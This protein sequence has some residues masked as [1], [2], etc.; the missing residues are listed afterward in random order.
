MFYH[1]K[2]I[3]Y[4]VSL[5][6]AQRVPAVLATWPTGSAYLQDQLKRAMSSVLLNTAEGNGRRTM[7]ERRRF[8]DIARGSASEVSAIMDV[9][10]ALKW[11][12]QKLQNEFQDK[13]LQ[14]AKI[15]SKL[16]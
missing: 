4:Q 11:I 9:A 7:K 10:H 5:A 1:Q 14:N 3:C 13:L 15:L 8:F 12:D 2:L 16:P 6:L